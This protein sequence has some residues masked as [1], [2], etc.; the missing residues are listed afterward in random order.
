MLGVE[1]M[2]PKTSRWNRNYTKVAEY[3]YKWGLWIMKEPETNFDKEYL[4]RFIK[5]PELEM[6]H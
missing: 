5:V 6:S 4:Y 3:Y 1:K 2:K